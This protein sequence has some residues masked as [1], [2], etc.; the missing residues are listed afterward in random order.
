MS[1]LEALHE[2][3]P[4]LAKTDD[5]LKAALQSPYYENDIF[6]VREHWLASARELES[7]GEHQLAFQAYYAAGWDEAVTN[8]MEIILERLVFNAEAGGASGLANIARLH[9]A[10]L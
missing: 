4:G 10:S 1:R 7:N 9:S 6:P 5:Y 3:K 2:D 8:D